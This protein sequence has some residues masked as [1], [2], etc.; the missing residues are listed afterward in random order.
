[1]NR[2]SNWNTLFF[3]VIILFLPLWAWAAEEATASAGMALDGIAAVVNEDVIA[4]SEL[5]DEL[6]TITAELQ[7]RNVKLPPAPVLERQVLEKMVLQKI[8]LQLAERTGVRIEDSALDAALQKMADDNHASL[9]Q[10]RQQLEK[11]GQSFARF[12]ESIREQ[13]K[14]QRLQQRHVSQKIQ[15]TVKEIDAF[16][17]NRSR[18]G[19]DEAEY[20]LLHILIAVPESATPDTLQTKQD[21]AREILAQLNQGADFRQVAAAESNSAQALEGG[22]LGWR[23]AGELP[24]LFSAQVPAMQV[25]EI[26]GPIRNASGFH[27]IKLEEKRGGAAAEVAQAQTRARHILIKTSEQLSEEEGKIRIEVLR[28]RLA[29]G[30]DFA[31]LAK[32]HS[33]DKTSA[34]QGG[35]LDW[36]SPG[37]MVPEFE[38]AM[39]SLQPGV[40]SPP[41]K[42]RYG[43]H[44]M[45]VM[46]RRAHGDA[47]E[48]RRAVAARQI[49]QRKAEEELQTWLRQLR[50]EAYVDYRLAANAI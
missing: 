32:A 35:V 46:E 50:D 25:G 11:E 23:K 10:F 41:V 27:I 42:T 29:A 17:A 40:T 28:D 31:A 3:I 13:M 12:R 8:Q 44:L 5:G 19:G 1:M 48:A 38:T 2:K 39:D 49:Q 15:V 37:D 7:A 21:K 9:E 24:T 6:Q 47:E 4:F 14:V 18:Q 22:D 33:E 36:L 16:L 34:A 26:A 43:W 30:E 20:H 45:Q